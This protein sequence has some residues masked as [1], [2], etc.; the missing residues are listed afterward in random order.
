MGPIRAF[1]RPSHGAAP[2]EFVT[3]ASPF[4]PTHR[5]FSAPHRP[6]CAHATPPS[7][8]LTP[9]HPHLHP[10]PHPY[11][12]TCT[13]DPLRVGLVSSS[14][15]VSQ[16]CLYH[17]FRTLLP[18]GAAPADP[19]PGLIISHGTRGEGH[20]GGGEA[21]KQGRW[22]KGK[23]Q[24]EWKDSDYACKWKKDKDE[25]KKYSGEGKCKKSDHDNK[26]SKYSEEYKWRRERGDNTC[27]K[28]KDGYK[29]KKSKDEYKWKNNREEFQW[30]AVRGDDREQERW[31]KDK[32][33]CKWK[34]DKASPLPYLSSLAKSD[35]PSSSRTVLAFP[36]SDEEEDDEYADEGRTTGENRHETW[37]ISDIVE[38]E[39]EE[40]EQQ[41]EGVTQQDHP[42]RKER[43]ESDREE[44]VV[45]GSNETSVVK[46]SLKEP[47]PAVESQ[48][49]VVSEEQESPNTTT[50]PEGE[51][52]SLKAKRTSE[53][54]GE[55]VDL[56]P[57]NVKNKWQEEETH[58]PPS[59]E[60]RREESEGEGDVVGEEEEEEKAGEEVRKEK[61]GESSE[62]PRDGIR[63][64]QRLRPRSYRQFLLTRERRSRVFLKARS[65]HLGRW[66]ITHFTH[67][68]PCKDQKDQLATRTNMTRNQVS[69]WFGNMRRRIREATRGMG[70]CWEER[71]RV[72]NSVITGKSEPLPIIP[73]D[74]IN[75]W[76]PPVPQEPQVLDSHEE[77]SA[78]P[79][80]K[81]TLLQRYLNNSLE[82]PARHYPASDGA[83]VRQPS[84]SASSLEDDLHSRYKT[85]AH[86]EPSVAFSQSLPLCTS[87]PKEKSFQALWNASF[88]RVKDGQVVATTSRFLGR[89]EYLLKPQGEEEGRVMKRYDRQRGSE[90]G[91]PS[92]KRQR[93]SETSEDWLHRASTSR[94]L[95]T[96]FFLS[97]RDTPEGG[98]GTT[99]HLS[100]WTNH[101]TIGDIRSSDEESGVEQCRRQPE[102]IAAAY[103]LMEL[104]NM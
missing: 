5:S 67:P 87:S 54:D 92:V 81:T 19:H 64:T 79:K 42:E 59:A 3:T 71:V 62:L 6:C 86:L 66:F 14:V 101:A 37:P 58:S 33:E 28:E 73:E 35:E 23:D 57:N 40:G 98:Q 56:H 49:N 18:P 44:E 34:K 2:G 91:S 70:I 90:Y 96:P 93:T 47:S 9:H 60:H 78:S 76:V 65:Y 102:E 82:A 46:K 75:T 15:A 36:F 80:F 41:P 61:K 84:T 39:D 7:S 32:D 77:V 13:S 10:H 17:P 26:W 43:E 104:Q 89:G 20:K 72:Y 63:A 4:S 11:C 94:D 29:W 8:T 99:S 103:T 30:K 1:I 85:S 95:S 16:P 74:A 53:H 12:Q 55:E 83:N 48:F 50:V 27:K 31:K 21:Q 22:R 52:S 24:S 69:E 100:S 88:E 51:S 38:T 25:F 68:Y 45:Q 97:R